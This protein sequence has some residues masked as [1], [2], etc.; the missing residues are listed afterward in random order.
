S[1][2]WMLVRLPLDEVGQ[3]AVAQ[4]GTGD[5]EPPVQDA[6]VREGTGA[7]RG[8]GQVVT[9]GARLRDRL[10]KARRLRHP[11]ADTGRRNLVD[12]PW[13]AVGRVGLLPVRADDLEI[14]IV[15][16]GEQRVV[17]PDAGVAAAGRCTHTEP[18]LEVIDGS[19]HVRDGIDD[20]VQHLRAEYTH[21]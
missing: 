9:G 13:A 1:D 7:R 19:S 17:R 3:D 12:A 21:L 10:F 16:D 2:G 4:R 18:L 5:A 11:R 6:A 15:A 8:I 14:A 20:V